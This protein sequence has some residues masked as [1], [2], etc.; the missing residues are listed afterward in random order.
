VNPAYGNVDRHPF[1]ACWIMLR[2]H[3]SSWISDIVAEECLDPRALSRLIHVSRD[4]KLWTMRWTQVAEHLTGDGVLVRRDFGPPSGFGLVGDPRPY[5]YVK[6][7]EAW[8]AAEAAIR[9]GGSKF[10]PYVVTPK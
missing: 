6:G 9:L 2:Q 5:W 8:K 4:Q 3:H 7:R 10:G 1:E